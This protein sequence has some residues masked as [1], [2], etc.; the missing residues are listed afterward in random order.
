MPTLHSAQLGTIEYPEEH[1]LHF[2]L[3]LPAF[4]DETRFLAVERP[5][6]EP[7][8]FLQSLQRHDL[9]FP[10]LPAKALDP[11]FELALSEDELAWLMGTD[12]VSQASQEARTGD[13][14]ALAIV[15]V[16]PEGI[17]ANLRAPVVVNQRTKVGIQAIQADSSYSLQHPISNAAASGRTVR[18]AGDANAPCS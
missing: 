6:M 1:V 12:A 7:I 3:G 15:T 8:V 9:A 18:D 11:A 4:E 13:L 16:S 10:T 14:I 2:P 5:G 17:T